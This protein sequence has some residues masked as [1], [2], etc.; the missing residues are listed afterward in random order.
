LGKNNYDKAEVEILGD[1]YTI[2]GDESSEYI[3]ELANYVDQEL[4]EIREYNSSVSKMRLMILGMMNFANKLYKS[5][6]RYENLQKENNNIKA[7]YDKL[8]D[9]YSELKK[10][11]QNL[12]EEFNE[13]LELLDEGGFD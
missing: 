4:K 12:E 10:K 6:V 5:K 11:Y 7:K 3:A 9:K 2:K 13:F 1:T 8:Q